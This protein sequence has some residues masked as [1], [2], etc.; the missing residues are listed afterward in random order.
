MLEHLVARGYTPG[1]GII[2]PEGVFCLHIPKNASTHSSNLLCHN[3]WR[4]SNITDPDIKQNIVILRDPVERWI[5]GFAT[6]AASWIL[7]PSYGSDAFNEDFNELTERFIFDQIVFDDHTTAQVKFIEQLNK[8]LPTTYFALNIDLH[9][10]LEMFL[11]TTLEHPE[12][13]NSN[14]TENNYD[15]K[16]VARKMEYILSQHPEYRAKLIECYRKDYDFIRSI[17]F[18]DYYNESR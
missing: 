1:S 11:K 18:Y 17:H 5:S 4:H 13:L 10:N 15:T 14:V 7:G 6:Y 12:N 9:R 2:S 3:G 8:N 16:S